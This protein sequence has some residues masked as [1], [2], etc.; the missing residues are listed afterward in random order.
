MLFKE[1]EPAWLELVFL[2]IV[3]LKEVNSSSINSSWLQ[4]ELLADAENCKSD[5]LER[6]LS[7][8]RRDISLL[9]APS[10]QVISS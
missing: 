1:F 2:L 4:T 6:K 9:V 3:R 10:L 8:L 7:V 5:R